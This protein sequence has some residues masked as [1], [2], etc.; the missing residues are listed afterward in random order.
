MTCDLRD[1][2]FNVLV[3]K[4]KLPTFIIK[5]FDYEFIAARDMDFDKE[6]VNC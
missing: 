4:C 1:E 3:Y 2:Y 6:S 5:K